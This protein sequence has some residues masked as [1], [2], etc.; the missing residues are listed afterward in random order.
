MCVCN[1]V[2]HGT[3]GIVR[4]CEFKQRSQ[5]KSERFYSETRE[6]ELLR[7][8][9]ILK[10]LLNPTI[11]KYL[12][13]SY[14]FFYIEILIFILQNVITTFNNLQYDYCDLINKF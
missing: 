7:P 6:R 11:I 8:T 9:L 3:H 14:D 5:L 2:M 13:F 1:R 10:L 4:V 12:G